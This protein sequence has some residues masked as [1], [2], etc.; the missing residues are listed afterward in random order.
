VVI[1]ASQPKEAQPVPEP[2]PPVP[3]VAA[4][5]SASVPRPTGPKVTEVTSTPDRPKADVPKA[6]T[7]HDEVYFTLGSFKLDNQAAL[8]KDVRWLKGSSDVQVVI[9]GHADPT[10][11]H[12]GNMVLSQKRA[13]SV[14]DFLVSAGIDQSRLEVMAYGDT[15][16]RYG[17]ADR[18]NRRAAIVVK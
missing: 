5:A 8:A 11:T 13:E 1:S 6:N 17:R 18:R 12:E 10:G 9:E 7:V 16:L 14:R 4:S 3:P 2:T 15:R